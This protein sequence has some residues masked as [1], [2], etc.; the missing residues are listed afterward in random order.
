MTRPRQ[1]HSVRLLLLVGALSLAA[2]GLFGYAGDA[3]PLASLRDRL[4]GSGPG[5]S[6]PAPDFAFD[7][8]SGQH[9]Q[10]ADF[11]GN[12]VVLNFWASWCIPCRAEM[13]YFERV[14]RQY[15]DRGVMFVGLAVEDD[16]RSAQDFLKTLG[17]TY[18][19]GIDRRNEA[20]SR[21]G[22]IGLP[23]TVFITPDGMIA[24]RWNGPVS[25]EQLTALVDQIASGT[26]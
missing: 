6:G 2:L 11:K 8:F 7:T 16:P 24:R 14:F 20:A 23:T 25:E 5:G 1:E 18:P 10:L 15:R 21:Y 22:V 17:V 12:A 9:T 4:P 26:K 13:P 3:P 19:T